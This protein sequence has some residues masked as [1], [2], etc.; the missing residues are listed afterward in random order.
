[1]PAIKPPAGERIGLSFSRERAKEL[2]AVLERNGSMLFAS[3]A[4][5][6]SAA[7]AAAVTRRGMQEP[8]VLLPAYTCPSVPAAVRHAGARPVL[9]D[10]CAG[11]LLLD[12]SALKTKLNEKTVA[13]ITV[14]PFG[15]RQPS[16]DIA[17]AASQVGAILIEDNAQGWPDLEPAPAKDAT[18]TILSFGRGKQLSI[19]GGGA[20]VINDPSWRGALSFEIDESHSGAA[21]SA[22]YAAKV[23]AYNLLRW[24]PAF[25]LLEKLTFTGIGETR[26]HE[27]PGIATMGGERRASLAAGLDQD[28]RD[29]LHIQTAIANFLRTARLE[30]VIDLAADPE[31]G[32]QPRLLRYPLLARSH[33]VREALVNAI[34]KRAVGASRMYGAALPSIANVPAQIARQGPFINA[35]LLANRL[36]TLPVHSGI[37]EADLR[38]IFTVLRAA[39]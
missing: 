24:P 36:L 35:K 7:V 26:Y 25:G 29:A 15:V 17:A 38:R 20:A 6:L 23:M 14:N 5:A 19:L 12:A 2:E 10:L 18:V 27:L 21:R 1:M 37:G 32:E 4:M 11:S 16:R 9:V 8:E 13:I 34:R 39:G 30:N 28:R 22:M 3:G 31:A 33:A